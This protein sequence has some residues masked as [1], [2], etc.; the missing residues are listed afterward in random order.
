M[1]GLK[2]AAS[3]KGAHAVQH[4]QAEE[5]RDLE[6]A[7]ARQSL[8]A[9]HIRG[10]VEIEQGSGLALGDVLPAQGRSMGDEVQLPDLLLKGHLSE[11]LVHAAFDG[12]LRRILSHGLGET[13]GR[14]SQHKGQ[15][16]QTM[17]I[18]KPHIDLLNRGVTLYREWR[19]LAARSCY[20]R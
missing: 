20:T 7:L 14:Q 5:R 2:A 12:L 11:K 19:S 15:S 6:A 16:H 13:R 4:V 1:R 3:P 9:G 8:G 10:A 17:D 18:R